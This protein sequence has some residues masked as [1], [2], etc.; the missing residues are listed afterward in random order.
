MINK[1]SKTWHWICCL[2]NKNI[3]GKW[4]YRVEPSSHTVGVNMTAIAL[5]TQYTGACS[6]G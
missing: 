1:Y 2:V 6:I 4:D 3:L 5:H